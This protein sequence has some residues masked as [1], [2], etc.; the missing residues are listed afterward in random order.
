MGAL[1]AVARYQRIKVMNPTGYNIQDLLPHR[2]PMLLVTE[3]VRVDEHQ[4]VTKAVAKKSWPLCHHG[5]VDPL[6]CIELVAQTAGIHNGWVR[7]KEEG[8]DVD[9]KGWIVGIKKA[10]LPTNAV[11]LGTRLITRSKNRFEFEGFR[12]VHGTVELKGTIIAE[13]VLQLLRSESS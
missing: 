7:E 11:T 2:D 1:Y 8:P 3:V 12:E 4:A 5:R 10:E 13:I 6:V 9:K